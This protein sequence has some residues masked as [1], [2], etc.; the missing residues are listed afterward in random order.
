VSGAGFGKVI[1]ALMGLGTMVLGPVIVRIYCEVLIL[2]FRMN[3]TLTDIRNNQMQV[4][5]S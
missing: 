3:E 2:F 1:G 5:P 4:P